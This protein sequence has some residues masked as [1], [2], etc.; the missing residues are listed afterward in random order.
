MP[1]VLRRRPLPAARDAPHSNPRPPREL[2][3]RVPER[4]SDLLEAISLLAALKQVGARLRQ[5]RQLRLES[6]L[7]CK[8]TQEEAKLWLPALNEL[9]NEPHLRRNA[10]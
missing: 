9:R 4:D 8:P 7:G 10:G 2:P 1:Q 3:A 5:S 6:L